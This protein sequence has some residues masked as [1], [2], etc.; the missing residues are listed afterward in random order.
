MRKLVGWLLLVVLIFVLDQA[1]KMYFSQQLAVGD[2]WII[3]PDYFSLTL[4][5]NSGAAFSFLAQEGGWQRWFFIA[6]A[7]TVSAVLLVWIKRLQAHEQRLALALTLVLAGSLGNVFDR[8][9]Y[10]HVIDF[11]LVHWHSRWYFPAFNLADSAIS[12][13]AALLIFDTF[14]PAKAPHA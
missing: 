9:V 7:L 11:I 10:G 13:G 12:L 3:I 6:V 1:S 2:E 4:A 14:K 8:I 5:Y